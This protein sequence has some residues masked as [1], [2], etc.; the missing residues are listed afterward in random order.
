MC[1]IP[2]GYDRACVNTP[3]VWFRAP[4][5]IAGS[6]KGFCYG[7]RS[8]ICSGAARNKQ[9][10]SR[11]TRFST[12][13]HFDKCHLLLKKMLVLIPNSIILYL[14]CIDYANRC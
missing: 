8:G 1:I 9:K 3:R 11:D 12:M 7:N 13:W 14:F 10:L 6:C 5:V 4:I 2:P